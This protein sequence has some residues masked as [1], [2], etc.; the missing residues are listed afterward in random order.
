[1]SDHECS[2]DVYRVSLTEEGEAVLIERCEGCGRLRGLWDSAEGWLP[3][4]SATLET[5]IARQP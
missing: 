2:F 1:M 4:V 5:W 3:V